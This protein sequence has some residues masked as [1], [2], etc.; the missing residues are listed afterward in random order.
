[1]LL[2]GDFALTPEEV[3]PYDASEGYGLTRVDL[4]IMR[5]PRFRSGALL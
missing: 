4:S 5:R 1:M 3:S 2:R